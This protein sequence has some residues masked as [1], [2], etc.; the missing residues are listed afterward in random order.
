[1]DMTLILGIIVILIVLSMWNSSK[2]K[3]LGEDIE[4]FKEILDKLY[5]TSSQKE[6]SAYDKLLDFKKTEDSIIYIENRWNTAKND[7]VKVK[8]DIFQITNVLFEI[9]T[10]ILE[11]RENR[12]KQISLFETEK[13]G[14]KNFEIMFDCIDMK[15]YEHDLEML[16]KIITALAEEKLKNTDKSLIDILKLNKLYQEIEQKKV[17]WE[18]K[19]RAVHDLFQSWEHIL[20]RQKALNNEILATN[21]TIE[22]KIKIYKDF[23]KQRSAYINLYQGIEDRIQK[24]DNQDIMLLEWNELKYKWSN[25]EV[26]I[27]TKI[28]QFY[29]DKEKAEQIQGKLLQLSKNIE[30]ELLS[31]KFPELSN[32]ERYLSEISLSLDEKRKIHID[33]E[34]WSKRLHEFTLNAN[35]KLEECNLKKEKEIEEFNNIGNNF[36]SYLKYYL[37]WKISEK[38]CDLYNKMKDMQYHSYS[39]VLDVAKFNID[40]NKDFYKWRTEFNDNYIKD[41]LKRYED[42]F[43]KMFDYPL[44]KQQRIAVLSDEDYTQVIAGAG[45]G[46]TTTIQAKVKFLVEKMGIS[47]NKIL[48]LAFNKSAKEE[49]QTRI[50]EDMGIDVDVHTFH[51]F[52]LFI[53]RNMSGPRRV[54]EENKEC[55]IETSIDNLIIRLS[56][57]MPNFPKLLL[58][59][60]ILYQIEPKSRCDYIDDMNSYFCMLGNVGYYTLKEVIQNNDT[61]VQQ[62]SE[63]YKNKTSLNGNRVRSYEELVIANYLYLNG[64]NYEYESTFPPEEWGINMNE[65]Y[66]P[67]FYLTD[68]DLYWEH[69]G[70]NEQGR[71]PYMKPRN[72]KKYISNMN[73]KRK[74]YVELGRELIE[75][76]SWQFKGGKIYEYLDEILEKYKIEKKPID[77]FSIV[78]TLTKR[79][80]NKL[81]NQSKSLIENY[82][83]LYKSRCFQKK[84]LNT[85]KKLIPCYTEFEK[86]RVDLFFSLFGEIYDEYEQ[87]LKEENKIDF[88]DMICKAFTYIQNGLYQ[89][90]YDYIIVD[91]Y[92]DMAYSR[93]KLLEALVF[94]KNNTK[95]FGVGDDWQSIYG[96]TGSDLNYFLKFSNYWSHSLQLK[97]EQTHRNSQ[98]LVNLAGNFI[99]KNPNQI[100]K[101]LKAKAMGEKPVSV[102]IYSKSKDK[103]KDIDSSVY[104][105]F[106]A[107]KMLKEKAKSSGSILEDRD[108]LILSR[109]NATVD[110][111]KKYTH[112]RYTYSTVHRSKGSEAKAVILANVLNG[113]SG[114]PN[115]MSDDIIIQSLLAEPEKFLY[116]QERRLFYVALTRTKGHIVITTE[117]SNMSSFIE[118]IMQ[119][120]DY[121]DYKYVTS[122]ETIEDYYTVPVCKLCNGKM[123]IRES[124]GKK[125]WGCVNYRYGCNYTQ[126][127]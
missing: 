104:A 23:L 127:L 78:Q 34:T 44:D 106:E 101:I 21:R 79:A 91:E 100:H 55:I 10:N 113:I 19:K 74:R 59:F 126:N 72:E 1:M 117:K 65:P 50:C 33:R 71:L 53:T 125:F 7:L 26:T 66:K 42:Y 43:D 28:E 109:N 58:D 95:L 14:R 114:F 56:K 11:L 25:L 36:I 80:E 75:S 41:N 40:I 3:I 94:Q 93:Q 96:F 46:K 20:S 70:I 124:R 45:S 37:S 76:Y 88:N 17:F 73:L 92:Q 119:E 57:K 83:N 32:F 31:N 52:G 5:E 118:E 98:E 16:D 29:K 38:L 97:I 8:E 77:L 122:L 12:K 48:L 99:M 18:G 30:L 123:V 61:L 13:K 103:D 87:I 112:G 2:L 84:D 60:A 116:A 6:K 90:P 4:A 85:A 22:E 63:D 120:R 115:Q 51:S 105:V 54:Y 110:N 102:L 24:I 15:K 107:I 9:D 89:V 67:D 47:P 81:F 62:V 64:I 86:K 108:I 35:S 69:F 27:Q 82:L 49:M 121:V 68:Y 111:I 39:G